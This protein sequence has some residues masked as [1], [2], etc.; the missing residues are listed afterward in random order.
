MVSLLPSTVQGIVSPCDKKRII[1]TDYGADFY[2]SST[3]NWHFLKVFRSLRT[4]LFDGYFF[5]RDG[6]DLKSN[7]LRQ[8]A[9]SGWFGKLWLSDTWWICGYGWVLAT[10]KANPKVIRC[11]TLQNKTQASHGKNKQ[12]K[13]E[14]WSTDPQ[15]FWLW[16]DDKNVHLLTHHF[17]RPLDASKSLNNS[18]RPNR[19]HLPWQLCPCR[20]ARLRGT[21]A[22][23]SWNC[24]V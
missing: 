10:E 20:V 24:E 8:E 6:R 16:E 1:Q 22:H 11:F 21:A 2:E 13:I 23:K 12:L 18:K 17:S 14:L 15:V 7:A 4:G 3:K 9:T 5:E 19:N